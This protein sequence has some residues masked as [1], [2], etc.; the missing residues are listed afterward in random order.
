MSNILEYN[1]KKREMMIK[2]STEE[3]SLSAIRWS[4]RAAILLL[5]G[6]KVFL[7]I[8]LPVVALK[9]LWLMIKGE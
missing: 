4:I 3:I 9:I 8:Y 2:N 5:F 6:V 1:E 7:W